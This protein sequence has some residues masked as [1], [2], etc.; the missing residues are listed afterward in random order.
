[1]KRSPELEQLRRDTLLAKQQRELAIMHDGVLS[2]VGKVQ[3][4]VDKHTQEVARIKAL[5]RGEKGEKGDRGE[6]GV[7]GKDGKDGKDGRDGKDAVINNEEIINATIK[8]I[9]QPKDGKDAVIDEEKIA[10]KAVD[11]IVEKKLIK[12]DSIDGLRN[13]IDSYRNQLAG[14]HYGKDTWARGGGDTVSAGTGI[15]ITALSDGTKQISATGGGTGTVT[16]VSVVSANG[17]AGSVADATTTPAITLTTSV[18]GILKGNGTAISAAVANTDYQVPITLTTTGSSGAATFD[19]T[20]LNIPQY[21]GGGGTVDTVVGTTDRITV[22][23]TDPANPIVDIAST[24]AGQNT[25]TTLGTITTG[26]WN[27]TD[28]ALADGGTGASLSDPNADRILFWDDSA[29]AVTWLEAGTGLTIT[30]TTI[31]ATGVASSIVVGT[32]TIT[33]GTNTRI[34]YNNSGVL[35]EYT[36]T[37]TGTVVAMQTA[38]TFATSITTPSVLATANDSGAIGASG[39]AFSD[40]FLASGAVIDFAAGNSV[41]THS[42]GVLTVSTGDLRVTTAGTNTASVVTVGGTQ[43]LT[44]KTLTS[45][46]ITTSPTAAGATWT[47]LG[48]V[49]TVALATV[50]GAVDMGGAT[51]FEIPNGA[52]GTTVNAAGEVCVDTTSD[53]LNFYDGTEEKVL[54]PI[55]SKAITITDPSASEDI[56]LFYTDEA[57]T[58]TKMVFVI[59]GSTSVTTTIRHGT[60][61]S[62]AGAEVVT[63][64]TVAN[65]TTTGNVVTSFNDATVV[66]DSFVWLETTALSGTPTSLNVTIFY[67]QDA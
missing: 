46:V 36:L 48:T 35:G 57:I 45:P 11:L 26:V 67:K 64:G 7:P 15:T 37:G 9:R 54:T 10:Q 58:I 19:G 13:E 24:Y 22:D 31:T 53:T 16:S 29:G 30:N 34:L 21:T 12:T 41:I 38:P 55:M 43:T 61:R 63:S 50:T 25:I 52:G 17:F 3:T 33:S 66:A 65:S 27:G 18:T 8:R 59:T 32:T 42:S 60:D 20:T 1:M 44:A 39:T 2:S 62:A 23:S 6:R 49:T 51:S 5:P 14:K 56:S 28:I 4:L 40:L 47:D